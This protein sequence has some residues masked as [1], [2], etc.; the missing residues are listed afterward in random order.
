MHM[1]VCVCTYIYICVCVCVWDLVD[2]L[3]VGDGR[4]EVVSLTLNHCTFILGFHPL[5]GREILPAKPQPLH[6]G[7]EVRKC[8]PS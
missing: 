5:Q 3:G 2:A 6:L 4:E 8:A 1:N 7:L